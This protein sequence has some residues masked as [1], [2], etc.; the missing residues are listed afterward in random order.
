MHEMNY[1]NTAMLLLRSSKASC[2]KQE[3]NFNQAL[4]W[5]VKQ[6]MRT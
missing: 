4:T 6:A 1:Q 2:E 3:K 5:F